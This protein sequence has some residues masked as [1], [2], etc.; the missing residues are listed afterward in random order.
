MPVSEGPAGPPI[1]LVTGH[2]RLRVTALIDHLVMGGAE[3]LLSQFARVTDSVGVDLSITCLSELDGNPAAVPLRNAGI[4]PS[5]LGIEGRPGLRALAAVRRHLADSRPHV[6][7]THLGN[8]DL[9]G[10]LAARSLGIPSVSTLH[11]TEWP[12]DNLELTVK[13]LVV[14]ACAHRLI[15]VSEAT[16]RAYAARI[17]GP[18]RRIVTIHNGV[19]VVPT[20]GAGRSVRAEFGIGEDELVIG[21]VSSLRREKAHDL[22]LECLATLHERHREVRLLIVGHGYM[23]EPIARQISELGLEDAVTMVG[24]RHDVM[25]FYD[26]FDVCLHP[27]WAEA[28]PTSLL[29]AM[30]AGVPVLATAVGGITEIVVDGETG[31]LVP[32]RPSP[33]Q[34]A[35]AAM[36]LLDSARLRTR[37][38]DAGRR[39]YEQNFTATPWAQRTRAL[40]DEL[41]TGRRAVTAS[42]HSHS[43]LAQ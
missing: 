6:L 9:L 33:S 2:R 30:A 32:A 38:G 34:L 1:S 23:A 3:M 12:G 16:R 21:M 22:A 7:H 19:D 37:M 5:S 13:R 42:G 20:P 10:G 18:T 14:G 40:Y 8:A 15:A 4:E 31:R 43:A 24:A 41:L 29:E 17:Y 25:P 36:E 26:A 35:D 11:S 27:S 39:R 28:F